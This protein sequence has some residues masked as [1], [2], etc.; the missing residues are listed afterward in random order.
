MMLTLQLFTCTNDG[1]SENFLGDR[2]EQFI[3]HIENILKDT[4]VLVFQPK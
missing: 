4:Q 1:L 2:T 3:R